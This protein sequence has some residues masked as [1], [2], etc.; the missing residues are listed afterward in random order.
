MDFLFLF[1]SMYL[2]RQIKYNLLDQQLHTIFLRGKKMF[3]Q[4][5]DDQKEVV[6]VC[7]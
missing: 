6:C 1:P 3:P 7:M 2:I 4:P 5:T